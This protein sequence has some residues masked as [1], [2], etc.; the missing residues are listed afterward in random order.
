MSGITRF[1]K[2]CLH[3]DNNVTDS[4]PSGHTIT[5]T[6]V[7][8][9][10]TGGKFSYYGIFNGTTSKL[11]APDSADFDL[12]SADFTID[13]W[14]QIDGANVQNDIVGQWGGAGDRAWAIEV[15]TTGLMRF[16]YTVDGTTEVT[17]D[18]TGTINNDTWYHVAIERYNNNLYHYLAGTKIGTPFDMTGVTI[19]NSAGLLTLGG[20]RGFYLSG[21]LDEP[22]F[23]KK[24]IYQGT[25]FTPSTLPYSIYPPRAIMISD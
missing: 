5:N 21:K 19:A 25:D 16:F 15:R 3:L 1:T 8:F 10:T 22:R 12:G 11:T 9:S 2:L 7:T 6:D 14:F 23:T 4:S 20:A 18:Q 13:T 17:K 24:A